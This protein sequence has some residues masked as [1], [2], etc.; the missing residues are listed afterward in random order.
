MQATQPLVCRWEQEMYLSRGQAALSHCNHLVIMI[1]CIA[2]QSIYYKITFSILDNFIWFHQN[3]LSLL[4]I[5][6][7][8]LS[9]PS[10][11]SMPSHTYFSF[12]LP[13]LSANF[14]I[15]HLP[16]TPLLACLIIIQRV[17]LRSRCSLHM[18]GNV[19]L[20][21]QLQH[22][23]AARYHILYKTVW[24]VWHTSVHYDTQPYMVCTTI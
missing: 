5:N 19:Q 6:C 9:L 1:P 12:L 13:F 23:W 15:H 4:I 17:S 16:P 2:L 20:Q 3:W 24:W 21:C 22:N 8:L 11:S 18:Y 14:L 7:H 10:L